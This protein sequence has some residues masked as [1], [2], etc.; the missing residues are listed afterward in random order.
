VAGQERIRKSRASGGFSS[1]PNFGD[2]PGDLTK[3]PK[4]GNRPGIDSGTSKTLGDIDS[5]LANDTVRPA[6][7]KSE[8]LGAARG[9]EAAR[10]AEPLSDHDQTSAAGIE[11]QR[12]HAEAL[13]AA[14]GADAAEKAGESKGKAN[15]AAGSQGTG[16]NGQQSAGFGGGMRGLF[17]A[18]GRGKK[19]FGIAGLSMGIIGVVFVLILGLAPFKL[20]HIVELL[21]Q[22]FGQRQDH[23]STLRV[24][25]IWQ[26]VADKNGNLHYERN[27]GHPLRDHIHN[28]NTRR[29]VTDMQ[30][31]GLDLG[32]DPKTGRITLH[33]QPI[34]G[35]LSD[36]RSTVRSLLSDAY[37]EDGYW[38][39]ALRTKATFHAYGISYRFFE[40]SR[41]KVNDWER[42]VKMKIRERLFGSV[43]DNPLTAS[44]TKDKN[45]ESGKTAQAINDL[46][47][48]L[49]TEA[50]AERQ[51]ALSDPNYQIPK[52]QTQLDD[53]AIAAAGAT[54][55]VKSAF[56]ALG[57]LTQACNIRNL[58]T[59]IRIAA[60]FL[61]KRSVAREAGSYLVAA[62][63]LMS[64]DPVPLGE[65]DAV[66]KTMDGFDQSPAYPWV[67]GTGP[68]NPDLGKYA[69][70]YSLDLSK[71]STGG[72][73][74]ISVSNAL[75]NIPGAICKVATNIFF[76]IGTLIGTL[77]LDFFTAGGISLA[78]VAINGA[79][80]FAIGATE[81]ILKPMAINM[82]AGASVTGDEPGPERFV[83]VAGGVDNIFNDVYRRNGG[84]IGTPQQT[85]VQ[86]QEIAKEQAADN[87]KLS[88]VNRVF[89]INNPN[90][91]MA[92]LAFAMPTDFSSLMD[93]GMRMFSYLN[94]IKF[95]QALVSP[96][97][98]MMRLAAPAHADY[99]SINDPLGVP[100]ELIPDTVAT[101]KE[102]D[103]LEA[104]ENYILDDPTRKAEWIDFH[105][106]CY[107]T[108]DVDVDNIP[109]C[110]D[111]S[112]L[113]TR[114]HMYQFDLGLAGGID[115]TTGS[116]ADEP[117]DDSWQ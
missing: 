46:N 34:D 94:P 7:S 86:G 62:H 49:G 90:S 22:Y 75:D 61:R 102:F 17:S 107:G 100:Q 60:T 20:I 105:D 47:Q 45:K 39:R 9:T 78:S 87:A 83:A 66:D 28:I 16:Q 84:F 40:D 30:K 101:S 56:D 37:P 57:I 72:A 63:T 4:G 50:A 92:R 67:S 111:S 95:E 31:R 35:D 110:N 32:L 38:R 24:G 96:N 44:S 27:T 54:D 108:D 14:K 106:K 6:R 10:A 68:P 59:E 71:G 89:N 21:N 3:I 33:G 82:L 53:A 12:E 55:T 41:E 64:G 29:L 79:S 116:T 13:G 65:L 5:A 114:F 91:A 115:F 74:F 93:S 36:R 70:E 104:E 8:E 25:K 85:F 43:D 80:S 23:T 19:Q 76:Q 77:V 48:Q 42:E 52:P 109:M 69:S 97:G 26:A 18:L 11:A 103:N 51:R 1:R 2:D 81:E 113:H 15:A 73:F 99:P 98:I 117:D 58:M 112:D 88:L